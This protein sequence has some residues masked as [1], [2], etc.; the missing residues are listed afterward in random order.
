MTTTQPAQTQPAAAQA[1]TRPAPRP[2]PEI[3][4]LHVI[5][6]CCGA[7]DEGTS[8]GLWMRG[9]EIRRADALC[10]ACAEAV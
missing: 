1:Q 3:L 5:C 9:W 6:D 10:R 8:A 2:A 7:E 4:R